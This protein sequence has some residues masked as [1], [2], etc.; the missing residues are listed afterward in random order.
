[1]RTGT[2]FSWGPKSDECPAGLWY[3]CA[4]FKDAVGS[5]VQETFSMTMEEPEPPKPAPAPKKK[6]GKKAKAG[7]QQGEASA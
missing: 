7:Q 1:M 2:S 4:Q 6:K 3:L 5:K